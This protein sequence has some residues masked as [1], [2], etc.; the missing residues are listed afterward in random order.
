[1][2][3]RHATPN[4]GGVRPDGKMT[5]RRRPG[6]VAK[7]RRGVQ[8]HRDVKLR[9]RPEEGPGCSAGGTHARVEQ[10]ACGRLH[11]QAQVVEAPGVRKGGIRVAQSE[12][13]SS[14]KNGRPTIRGKDDPFHH[15]RD[16]TRTSQRGLYRDRDS[17]ARPLLAI[18][19][20]IRLENPLRAVASC[21]G[22]TSPRI[23]M[24]GPVSMPPGKEPHREQGRTL[25]GRR[26]QRRPTDNVP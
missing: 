1:M 15:K 10:W 25:S 14:L 3:G 24:V 12:D 4:P 17:L 5:R 11:P 20:Y 13:D 23:S 18:D 7:G 21:Y 19:G 9:L 22:P 6:G 16:R 26:H 8:L 2:R